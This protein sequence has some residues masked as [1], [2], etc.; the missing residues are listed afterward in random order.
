MSGTPPPS[1]VST[2]WL[3]QH[4][5]EPDL[6]VVDATWFLPHEQR[7]ATAEFA[8]LHIPGAVHFDL[9]AIA[10]RV[11]SLP[12]MLPDAAS[13]ARAVGA[14]GIG[15]GHRIVVYERNAMYAAARV[16]WTFRVFGHAQVAVLDGGFAKWQSESL[17]VEL[18][19]P[20]IQRAAFTATGPNPGMVRDLAQVLMNNTVQL[21]DARSAGRF[22]GIDPEPRPGL[23]AGHIPRSSNLP[24][25]TLLDP[26]T[27]T[28]LPDSELRQRFAAARIDLGRP[29]VC[30]C[31][32]GV[33][34]ALVAFALECAGAA[35]VA[36][37]DGSWA[38]WGARDDVPIER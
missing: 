4:L 22:K 31:G 25:P 34:A 19:A 14:L 2:A 38:E 20:R 33:T 11:T 35:E 15:S 27:R 30:Y 3:A 24:Y 7:N 29:I 1:L 18:G 12:H 6:R 32:S 21:V 10:D 9:D 8:A 36:V 26:T 5:T 23:R 37:Y 28:L 13:F 16:W 17:P